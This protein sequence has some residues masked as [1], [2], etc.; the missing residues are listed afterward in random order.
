MS[1]VHLLILGIV[2][3]LT[4]FLPISSTAHLV[5]TSHLLG[6]PQTEFLK[7]FEV[8]IQSGAILAAMGLYGKRLLT[9]K[10]LVL[11]LL[12]SFIPTAILGILVY[13]WV[14][15][16]L[17]GNISLTLLAIFVGGL[18]LLFLPKSDSPD[19]HLT[20]SQAFLIGIAQCLAFIPGVSR[21]AAVIVAG[22]ILKKNRLFVTE[23]S[24]MLAIP[25]LLSAT[26][27]DM[28]KTYRQFSASEYFQLGWGV[29]ISALVA[30]LAIKYF[31]NYVKHHSLF[32]FGWYRIILA[33]VYLSILVSAA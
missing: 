14:K 27:L 7:T 21:A 22:L 18:I 29:I 31:I 9:Q 28:L 30:A 16:L 23:Y 19:S 25:T 32:V 10:D 24:F 5:L 4:E 17:I 15:G 8:A 13:P 11:N 3:G 1:G 6:L 2:E 33:A 12:L 26:A 20:H